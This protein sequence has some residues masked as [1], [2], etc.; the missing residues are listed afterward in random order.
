MLT[1]N[2]TCGR[3]RGPGLL[4]ALLLPGILLAAPSEAAVTRASVGSPSVGAFQAQ[5]TLVELAAEATRAVV[6]IDV[7]T[8]TDSR[9]GSGFIVDAAGRILTNQHVIRNAESLQVKLASGDVYDVVQILATDERRDM[10]VLQRST[11]RIQSRLR[12]G[13][14]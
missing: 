12:M 11:I 3:H 10:A 5:D 1:S 13:A 14:D 6:L 4:T 8:A 9:Q 2:R 7:K